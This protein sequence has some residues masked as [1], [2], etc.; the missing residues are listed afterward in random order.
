MEENSKTVSQWMTQKRINIFINEIDSKSPKENHPT[1]KTNI[2]H[3]D[4][5]WSLDIL[6]LTDYSP[7]N[8][9][10]YKYFLFVID[11]FSNFG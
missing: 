8:K 6:H 10:G 1:N 7:E 2:Y 4:G 3:I 5:N 9:R 11:N